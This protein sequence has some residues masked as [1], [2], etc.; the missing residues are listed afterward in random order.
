MR[1]LL[2]LFIA[3]LPFSL[4]AQTSN[5]TAT[6]TDSD[7]QIWNNGSYSI[8][9]VP[10]PNNPGPYTQ[11]DVP[12]NEGP[13]TGR[14]TNSGVLVITLPDN[15]TIQPAGSQWQFIICPNAS[16]PCGNRNVG[17]VGSAP[18]L[19]GTLSASVPVVRFAAI[20]Q[21][22]GYL[23]SEVTPTPKPGGS[24]WNVSVGC[25]K[26]WSGTSWNCSTGTI[27]DLASP[28]P[29]GNTTPNEIDSSSL[30]VRNLFAPS[31]YNALQVVMDNFGTVDW[32]SYN[33][34]GAKYVTMAY[35]SPWLTQANQNP[36][37][38]AIASTLEP[39]ATVFGAGFGTFSTFQL[40]DPT[41]TSAVAHTGLGG[42]YNVCYNYI[43]INANSGYSKYPVS[44]GCDSNGYNL[45]GASSNHNTITLSNVPAGY[46]DVAF[47]RTDLGT[48]YSEVLNNSGGG[49]V[50]QFPLFS[51]YVSQGATCTFTDDGSYYPLTTWQTLEG[52][53]YFGSANY[54]NT[55][56]SLFGDR[57]YVQK[58]GINIT[59]D[60]T[61]NASGSATNTNNFPSYTLHILDSYWDG[62]NSQ[63]GSWNLTALE[64]L[65]SNPINEFSFAHT[66]SPGVSNILMPS[67][68]INGSTSYFQP[69]NTATSFSNYPSFITEWQGSYWN[70]SVA[71]T[72][73]WSTQNVIGTGTTPTSTFTFVHSGSPGK[74]VVSVPALTAGVNINLTPV[75]FA[76]LDTSPVAGEQQYCSDCQVTTAATCSTNAPADCV[77][78]NSGS[79]AFAK[80]ENYQGHGAGWYCQ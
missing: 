72:D 68:V 79:G 38:L 60:S 7:S 39:F 54:N 16:S 57:V 3:L 33:Y 34:G 58:N 66:G 30:W 17:V 55:A 23:D 6:I 80:Y 69:Q 52:G 4:L 75:A 50:S 61:I 25:L 20:N 43:L 18:D 42:A 41:T 62:T 26:L 47:C 13:F 76:S 63:I 21:A 65:G 14:L 73:F 24:Y 53:F 27:V 2:V 10:T 70:G 29:V 71:I 8:N 44:A 78:K 11:N 37:T 45:S 28:P 1:K 19:S 15:S 49:V 32:N 9:F 51:C 40:A 67:F 36:G 56:A 64:G 59:G 35:F 22:Y 46:S 77:C 12:F 31:I 48:C 5:V 74:A